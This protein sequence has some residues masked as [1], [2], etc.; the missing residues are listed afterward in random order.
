MTGHRGQRDGTWTG[1]WL[2]LELNLG[3]REEHD[4]TQRGT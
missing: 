4:G 3:H 1:T 2:E